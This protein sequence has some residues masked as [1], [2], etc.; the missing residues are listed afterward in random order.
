MKIWRFFRIPEDVENF[1]KDFNLENK[2]PL[3]AIT[4]KKKYMKMF[5]ASRDMENRY[6]VKCD[7]VDYDEGTQYMQNN[8]GSILDF[9]KLRTYMNKDIKEFKDF[10]VLMTDFEYRSF[11]EISESYGILMDL[12]AINPDIFNQKIEKFLLDLGYVD[13]YCLRSSENVN[14]VYMDSYPNLDFNQDELV[15]FIKI[16]LTDLTDITKAIKYE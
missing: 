10:K 5:K 11:D 9:Y 2:Y 13:F 6:I 12:N 16:Y 3:Y 14:G 7:D 15:L 8:R 4:N 1:S